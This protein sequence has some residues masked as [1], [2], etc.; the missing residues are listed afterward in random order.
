MALQKP[1][2]GVPFTTKDNIAVDGML[3]T[4]GLYS[5]AVQ[6]V[7]ADKDAEVVRRMREAGAIPLAITNIPELGMAFETYSKKFGRTKNAYHPGRIAGG[8][9]GG[10]GSAIA[11]GASIVGVGS[12]VGGSIR[13]PAFFNGIYGLKP[14]EGSSSNEGHYPPATDGPYCNKY[15]LS[16]PM[17]RFASDLLPMLKVLTNP[18]DAAAMRLSYPMPNIKRLK[19]YYM[20]EIE[21]TVLESPVRKCLKLAQYKLA[22]E[23]ESSAGIQV[24]QVNLSASFA[25]SFSMWDV[26]LSLDKTRPPFT[27]ALAGEGGAAKPVK[28]W[29]EM[30]KWLVGFGYGP[31][32]QH[33]FSG[34]S[35][36]LV[37]QLTGKF[38]GWKPEEK[39]KIQ[40]AVNSLRTELD[41][42]LGDDGV[43]L[44][45]S[46]PTPAPYHGMPCLALAFNFSYTAIF[47]VLGHPA[48]QIPLGMSYWGVPLGVQMIASR[49]KEMNLIAL[50]QVIEKMCGGWE[51]PCEV[52]YA[53]LE[54]MRSH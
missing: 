41:T 25:N 11:S 6:N 37:Q 44:F 22:K 9:S 35:Y 53:L 47:N 26:M 13:M 31:W 7:K 2:L 38:L 34:I 48:L 3:F 23:L 43:L 1:L 5:R 51:P 52:D 8:S 42:L 17:C 39:A 15:L 19:V 12:D 21:D 29:W 33:T 16:G 49:H 27:E 24:E 4:G 40:E 20:L 45:Q 54:E 36:A 10:E 28:P 32:C 18:Q 46:H 30:V 50:A 14:T